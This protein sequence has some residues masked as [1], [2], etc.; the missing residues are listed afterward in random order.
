M[1]MA[2]VLR[3]FIDSIEATGGVVQ[4][5]DG[6]CYPR[7]DPTWTDLGSIYLNACEVAGVQPMI[8][9]EAA[10]EDND[11]LNSTFI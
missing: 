7:A 9:Y 8:V 10:E 3:E 5:A 6:V 11:L 2:T 4:G 1:T